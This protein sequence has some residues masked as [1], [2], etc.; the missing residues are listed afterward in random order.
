RAIG[1]IPYDREVPIA[2][3][4]GVPVSMS[5]PRSSVSKA[6][7]DIAEILLPA[8]SSKA[9]RPVSDE[10]PAPLE[11]GDGRARG[12]RVSIRTKLRKAA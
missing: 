7:A 6:I 8:P 3:N 4:R 5:A 1:E 10:A 9:R 2:V 12:K 11:I